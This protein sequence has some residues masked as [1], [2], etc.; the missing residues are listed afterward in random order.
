MFRVD[1]LEEI[2]WWIMASGPH[3]RV[4]KP[5]EL[6]MRIAELHAQAAARY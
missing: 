6:R 4:I 5:P 1:G 3:C 2:V